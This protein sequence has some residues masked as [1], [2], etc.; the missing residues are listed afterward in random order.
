MKYSLT[1]LLGDQD[2]YRPISCLLASWSVESSVAGTSVCVENLVI[3]D[4]DCGACFI[5][6]MVIVG[7]RNNHSHRNVVH[8]LHRQYV[9]HRKFIY[10]IFLGAK[11]CIEVCGRV[12]ITWLGKEEKKGRERERENLSFELTQM[13][14]RHL[15]GACNPHARRMSCLM[16]LDNMCGLLWLCMVAFLYICRFV[17]LISF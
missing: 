13:A 7:A 2:I 1:C 10:C 11:K 15:P 4:G 5:E 6:N 8:A 12:G 9:L 14:R 17:S 16:H 3:V